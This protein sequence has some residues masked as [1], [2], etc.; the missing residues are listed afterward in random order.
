MRPEQPHKH[1]PR[2]HSDDQEHDFLD[3]EP[4]GFLMFNPSE[5]VCLP[6]PNFTPSSLDRHLRTD[7]GHPIAPAVSSR[8]IVTTRNIKPSRRSRESPTGVGVCGAP[9]VP[10]PALTGVANT[11]VHS[12]SHADQNPGRDRNTKRVHSVRG[13]TGWR[14]AIAIHRGVFAMIRVIKA[15]E[16]ARTTIPASPR[17][18]PESTSTSERLWM[19]KATRFIRDEVPK[20]WTPSPEAGSLHDRSANIRHHHSLEISHPRPVG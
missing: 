10:Q 2:P 4:V 19:R 16:P 3:P 5:H 15:D 17:A 12:D 6:R 13:R 18:S 14:R 11:G 7:E 8:A 1:D 9:P 20:C